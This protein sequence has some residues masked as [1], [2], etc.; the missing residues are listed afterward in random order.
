[1]SWSHLLLFLVL[2]VMH[3]N[4]YSLFFIVATSKQPS[5][6][7]KASNPRLLLFTKK[8]QRVQNI[9]SFFLYSLSNF[10]GVDIDWIGKLTMQKIPF[11]KLIRTYLCIKQFL[12]LKFSH[13]RTC[14]VLVLCTYVFPCLM[15]VVSKYF[16]NL[17]NIYNTA[18]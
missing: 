14:T 8:F 9:E 1:M 11:H 18:H 12:F 15:L 2:F 6:K 5:K 10:L 17:S 3:M 7:A 4:K 16:L 13:Q